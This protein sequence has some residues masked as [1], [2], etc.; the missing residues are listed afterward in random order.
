MEF[1]AE[2][3]RRGFGEAETDQWESGIESD[4]LWGT[5]AVSSVGP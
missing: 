4:S 1:E 3:G 2:L 5:S